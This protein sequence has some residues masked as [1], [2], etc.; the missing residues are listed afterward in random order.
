MTSEERKKFAQALAQYLVNNEAVMSVKLEMQDPEA[1]VWAK[2]RAATPLFGYVT[3]KQAAATLEAWL[4]PDVG[5]CECERLE[6]LS[7]YQ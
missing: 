5:E 1:L 4:E 2:V 6:D 3:A 7:S